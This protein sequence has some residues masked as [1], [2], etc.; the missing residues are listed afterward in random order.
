MCVCDHYHY[1]CFMVSYVKF[2]QFINHLIDTFQIFFSLLFFN[3]N[4][5]Y[6]NGLINCVCVRVVYQFSVFCFQIHHSFNQML[7]LC[8][9]LCFLC[10]GIFSVDQFLFIQ[11]FFEQFFLLIDSMTAF[12]LLACIWFSEL[13]F[14]HNLCVCGNFLQTFD[15]F[16]L[17]IYWK[18]KKWP[19]DEKLLLKWF[20]VHLFISLK[21]D[22]TI[23]N[24]IG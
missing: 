5:E 22:R 7:F 10:V 3:S 16:P 12:F 18:A 21:M 11:L 19:D 1:H 9:L 24:E 15:W 4:V 2:I 6:N 23:F 8:V 20:K 17:N 13:Y 14:W